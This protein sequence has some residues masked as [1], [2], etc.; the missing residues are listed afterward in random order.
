MEI[1]WRAHRLKEPRS[2]DLHQGDHSGRG[3]N[4]RESVSRL[5]RQGTR[6]VETCDRQFNGSFAAW[7]WFGEH[8]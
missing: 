1:A 5:E 6:Q 4:L 7:S 2:G 3:Q 8:G